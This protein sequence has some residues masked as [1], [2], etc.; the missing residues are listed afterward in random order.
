M[1]PRL[2]LPPRITV[3]ATAKKP[4]Y[5]TDC[6]SVR[7]RHADSSSKTIS[8]MPNAT[9]SAVKARKARKVTLDE[10]SSNTMQ[11]QM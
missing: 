3:E 8:A 1:P 6:K 4:N 7:C 5:N 10:H 9:F 11:Q 2:L